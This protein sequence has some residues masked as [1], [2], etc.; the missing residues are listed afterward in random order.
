MSKTSFFLNKKKKEN[1]ES[2]IFFQFW[3]QFQSTK[4]VNQTSVF[5]LTTVRKYCKKKGEMLVN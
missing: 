3:M 4:D 2:S 5:V 1:Q